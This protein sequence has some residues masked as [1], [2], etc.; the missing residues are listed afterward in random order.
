MSGRSSSACQK[1]ACAIQDCLQSNGYNEDRCSRLI[2]N[3]YKCCKK[4][5]AE[6]PEIGSRCCPRPELLKLKLKQRGLEWYAFVVGM[7]IY[8]ANKAILRTIIYDIQSGIDH[9]GYY[10]PTIK[11]NC[12]GFNSATIGWRHRRNF[13]CAPRRCWVFNY[14]LSFLILFLLKLDFKRI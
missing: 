11:I 1:E 12:W 13:A 10:Y 8:F 2:D 5:Y 14:C 6:N 9:M 3:L 7:F 4:F